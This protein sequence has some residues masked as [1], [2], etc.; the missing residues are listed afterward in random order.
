M[1]SGKWSFSVP[2]FKKNVQR[3]WP[4]W[5]LYLLVY[6]FILPG[7]YISGQVPFWSD[8]TTFVYLNDYTMEI[9]AQPFVALIYG[10]VVACALWGYLFNERAT[11]AMHALPL[12]RESIFLT[13][14]ITGLL[15]F[16]V[17]SLVVALLTLGAGAAVGAVTAQALGYWILCQGLMMIFFFSL[18]TIMAFVTG[19]AVVQVVLYSVANLFCA[20]ISMMLSDL[21]YR[22]VYG[23]SSERS[24]WGIAE[25]GTPVLA[26]SQSVGPVYMGDS[27]RVAMGIMSG[28]SCLWIFAVVGLV[29]A[30]L[31]LLAYRKRKLEL[32]GEVIAISWFRPVFKYG[33]A[34]CGGLLLAQIV[35]DTME[36]KGIIVFSFLLVL[37]AALCYFGVEM[38]LQK[39]LRVW[40]RG[41]RGCCIL[42]AALL[43]GM[44]AM[45]Q[46]VLAYERRVPALEQV[47][48]VELI[49]ITNYPSEG[50]SSNPEY[51]EQVI[52]VHQAMV[53]EKSEQEQMAGGN[54]DGN[55]EGQ[56]AWLYIDYWMEDGGRIS[57]QYDLCINMEDPPWEGSAAWYC[58]QLAD[59]WML[60]SMFPPE[61]TDEEKLRRTELSYYSWSEE[62]GTQH[63]QEQTLVEEDAQI[64]YR[65]VREDIEAG[66]LGSYYNYYGGQYASMNQL[67][68]WFYFR[69]DSDDLR[70]FSNNS[71]VSLGYDDYC[72][73]VSVEGNAESTLKALEELGIELTW[74]EWQETYEVE[75]REYVEYSTTVPSDANSY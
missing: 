24:F 69:R 1:K 59:R 74:E 23:F 56:V 30:V 3:F 17:P 55:W 15:F 75:V 4:I 13:N 53:R 60:E 38:L 33:V 39:S 40:K 25:W 12:R 20:G 71:A 51:I 8:K 10:L 42:A 27:G 63:W 47:E 43:L 68:L 48:R 21:F 29:L 14:Y 2:L 54:R 57:R 52:A 5:G 65:A 19:N 26:I 66:R 36:L 72:V 44:V 45:E 41:W 9:A 11:G 49:G 61:Y 46:D 31:A 58:N 32:A 7:H 67:Q 28:M 18:A 64:L 34:V 73:Y 50:M 6:L 16:L 62:S 70:E 37:F 22:F 35:T